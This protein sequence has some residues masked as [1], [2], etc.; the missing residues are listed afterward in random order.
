MHQAV[1]QR[2]QIG[3]HGPQP[4]SNSGCLVQSGGRRLVQS[5]VPPTAR[6]TRKAGGHIWTISQAQDDHRTAVNGVHQCS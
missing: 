4:H 2:L 1:S 6:V 5:P 3:M